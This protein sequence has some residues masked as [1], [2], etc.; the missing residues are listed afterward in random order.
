[1]RVIAFIDDEQ[2]TRLPSILEYQ[3]L[4][5]DLRFHMLSCS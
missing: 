3:S 1:M 5:F 4:P 2:V